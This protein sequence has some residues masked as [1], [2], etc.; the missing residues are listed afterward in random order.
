MRIS[1]WSSDVCS[2]DLPVVLD[3]IGVGDGGEALFAHRLARVAQQGGME[4]TLGLVGLRHRADLRPV[5]VGAQEVVGHRQVAVLASLEQV[6]AA[7]APEVSHG[8]SIGVRGG[9]V[10]SDEHTSELQ[11]LMR[12]SYAVFSLKNKKTLSENI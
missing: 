5:Q 1:D 12:I 11:S 6:V 9:A 10:R 8:A 7:V 4:G 3:G 2:S